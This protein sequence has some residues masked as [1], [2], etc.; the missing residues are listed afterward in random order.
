[1]DKL[2]KMSKPRTVF[3]PMTGKLDRERSSKVFVPRHGPRFGGDRPYKAEPLVD[4]LG[5]SDHRLARV[6]GNI[7]KLSI[8]GTRIA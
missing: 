3:D 6:D 4:V 7:E 1:M 8:R 2:Q 5:I